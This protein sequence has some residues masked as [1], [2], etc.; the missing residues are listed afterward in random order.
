MIK[1]REFSDIYDLVPHCAN[2]Y[3]LDENAEIEICA[4]TVD[5]DDIYEEMRLK[6]EPIIG[7]LVNGLAVY[8]NGAYSPTNTEDLVKAICD[9]YVSLVFTSD[10]NLI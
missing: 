10:I 9:A 2:R 7:N 3:L 1:N 4:T 5:G 8:V 6:T